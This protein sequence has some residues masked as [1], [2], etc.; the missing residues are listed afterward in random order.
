M[1]EYL[2]G[3]LYH[4]PDRYEL[5]ERGIV[6][7]CESSTGIFIYAESAEDAVAWGDAIAE[8]LLQRCNGDDSLNWRK[9]GYYCWVEPSPTSCH[10]S[11]C[12]A[13]FQRVQVGEWPNLDAMG[14]AAYVKWLATNRA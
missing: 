11:H 3:L 8:K 5:Y 7:D 6:E 14:T 4:E 1:N 10:W 9:L 2:V 13:F 12:L